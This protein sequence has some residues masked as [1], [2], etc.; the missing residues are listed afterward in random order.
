MQSPPVW[1]AVVVNYEAGLLLTSCVRSVLADAS[2]GPPEVVVVDNGSTDGSI[3]LL[4]TTFPEVP[5]LRPGA[6]LGYARAANLGIAATRAPIVAVLNPDAEI[7]SGTATAMLAAFEGDAELAAVG[8][9]IRNPDGSCYASARRVPSV[10][11][12]LG[13]AL[14][15]GIAPRNRFTRA[16]RDL[17]ADPD[18]S[19]TVDWISGAALWLR[20]TALDRV[21]GWDERYFLFFEDVDLCRSLEADGW[22]IAYEPAG[23]VMHLVG[24]SRAGRRYRSIYEHHRAAYRYAAKWWHGPRRALLPVAA[25]FLA[26]RGAVLAGAETVRSR[27]V[28][29]RAT[30]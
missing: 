19:R 13:H 21:G 20:R 15:G 14:L 11:A 5:V 26:A 9:Q 10:G 23:Q 30:G 12:A 3:A 8:P 24:A 27:P 18:R 29:S 6:N 17:D 16:Y 22:R 28:P 2:A 4:E 25:A 1:A 7:A